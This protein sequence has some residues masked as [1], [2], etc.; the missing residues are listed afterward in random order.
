MFIFF[1]Y[2]SRDWH[3]KLALVRLVL[4]VIQLV[5]V[6]TYI[7]GVK[8]AKIVNAVV[9]IMMFLMMNFRNL[10]C[11]LEHPEIPN[12]NSLVRKTI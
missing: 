10:T 6:L 2:F 9:T 5:R 1:K 3:T 7:F 8:Y 11:C 12:E 4:N